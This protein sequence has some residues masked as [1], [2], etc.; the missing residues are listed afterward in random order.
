MFTDNSTPPTPT[1]LPST[2]NNTSSSSSQFFNE[3]N[4]NIKRAKYAYNFL[5]SIQLCTE[6]DWP[7]KPP[8]IFNS[9]VLNQQLHRK[10]TCTRL[11]HTSHHTNDMMTCH[12]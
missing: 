6:P 1:R 3:A 8:N 10:H 2:L 7:P 9:H 11:I 12:R 4:W 5:S